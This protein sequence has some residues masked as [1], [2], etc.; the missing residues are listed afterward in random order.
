MGGAGTAVHTIAR[1]GSLQCGSSREEVGLPDAARLL[2]R[3]WADDLRLSF[4]PDAEQRSWRLLTRT[5][6]QHTRDITRLR[7][8]IEGLLEECRIKIS[9]LISD[10]LGARGRRILRALSSGDRT[11]AKELAALADSRLRA[12]PEEL[13]RALNGELGSVHRLLLG[14]LMDDIE[15]LERHM[16]DLDQCLLSQLAQHQDVIRPLCAVPGVGIESA[17]T[18]LAELDHG[19]P[20]SPPQRTPLHGS[21]SARAGTRAQANRQRCVA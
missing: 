10:L 5:R 12:T 1:A 2:K 19:R 4:V 8:R 9:G 14:Q 3:L 15:L 17:Q 13:E 7:N 20:H 11:D 6:V 16:A 18:M 21:A